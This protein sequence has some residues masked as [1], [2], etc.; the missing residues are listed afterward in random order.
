MDIINLQLYYG[1]SNEVTDGQYFPI[2]N[3]ISIDDITKEF[4]QSSTD[5]TTGLKRSK[6]H[7]PDVKSLR[8]NQLG[9]LT[10]N[11]AINILMQQF[12]NIKFPSQKIYSPKLRI[13]N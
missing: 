4:G 11:T 6:R 9:N 7:F 8:Q 10:K 5:K 12:K 1:G 3:L 13:T 2:N